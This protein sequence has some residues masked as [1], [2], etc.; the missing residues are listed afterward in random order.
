MDV[1]HYLVKD[2]DIS[3]MLAFN[4][5]GGWFYLVHCPRLT[6]IEGVPGAAT[7]SEE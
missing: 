3:N 2:E 4:N 1:R 6:Q 7:Q 5:E